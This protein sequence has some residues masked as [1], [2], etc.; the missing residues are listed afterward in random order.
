MVIPVRKMTYWSKYGAT[1][2]SDKSANFYAVRFPANM[3]IKTGQQ[4]YEMSKAKNYD[5]FWTA[6]TMQIMR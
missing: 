1:V 6:L 2:K 5:E 4:L 3:N